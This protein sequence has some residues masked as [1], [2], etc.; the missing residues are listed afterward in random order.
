[1]TA[2]PLCGTDTASRSLFFSLLLVPP[3]PPISA[4][5][6]S[7][8]GVLL[9]PPVLLPQGFGRV[10]QCKPVDACELSQLHNKNCD[11]I[12]EGVEMVEEG[13]HQFSNERF[14]T[15]TF[16]AATDIRM[17]GYLQKKRGVLGTWASRYCFMFSPSLLQAPMFISCYPSLF[18]V[19]YTS[20]RIKN[21]KVGFSSWALVNC[22]RAN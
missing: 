2:S 19:C 4:S 16:R 14:I 18:L 5:A 15:A 7:L 8:V 10:A 12:M 20:N 9:V 3:I 17:E 6:F 21:L 11:T 1:M 13:E 22:C